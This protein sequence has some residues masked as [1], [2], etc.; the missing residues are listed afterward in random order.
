MYMVVYYD[1]KGR[2]LDDKFNI[3]LIGPIPSGLLKPSSPFAIV[4]S[5][6]TPFLEFISVVV[7]VAVVFFIRS[8]S[9]LCISYPSIQATC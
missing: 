6:V 9:N 1:E 3:R 2:V 8:R 4:F 7:V 5:S